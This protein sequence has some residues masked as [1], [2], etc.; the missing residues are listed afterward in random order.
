MQPESMDIKSI[1][2]EALEKTDAGERAA[3]LDLVCGKDTPQRSR[4]ESLLVSYEQAGGFLPSPDL[5]RAVTLDSA[6]LVEG[7]ATVVGRY[8]LLE[9]IGE[10]GMA[11][12]Y[13]AEQQEP[14]RRKVAL[15]IIKLGMDTRQIIAR[16]EAE[17][18]ALAVLDHPNIAKVFDAG[19]TGTGRPYFVME[20]VRGVSI[21]DYCDQNRL[22]T[23]ARLALFVQVCRAVQHAHHK[24]I[25]HRDLKPSNVMVTMHDDKPVPKVIDFGIAKAINDNQRLT[26]KTLFTRY[27]HM[28]GTPAYMS[29]EQAQMSGLDVDTRTDIYSL[30]VLLY[31]LLTGTTPFAPETLQEAGYAEIER[32]IRETNPPKPST[33]LRSLGQ[34]GV[35]AARGRH[36]GGEAL[37]RLV[38]GDLDCIAMKCLE[39][40]R[41]RRYTTAHEIAE[42]IERHLIHKPILARP[43]GI[44]YRTQKFAQRNRSR[45]AAASVFATL[46]ASFV[47]TLAMYRQHG[48][49]ESVRWAREQGLPEIIRLVDH[50]D[51]D[52]AFS[53]ARKAYQHIP[54]DPVL[55]E[56][57]SQICRDYSIVTAPAGAQ[58]WYR[59][60]S[61]MN[62]PWQY[63]GRSPLA[64][65]TLPQGPHRWKIEKEGF[66]THECVV[67]NSFEVRLQPQELT[68]DMVWI[69][70]QMVEL[71]A[72]LHGQRGTVEMPEH[73]IDRYEVT[74]KQFKAFVDAG[75][76]GN[77]EYW[78]GLDFVKEGRPLSWQEAMAE[79]RDQTG[80]S[81]PAGWEGGMYRP[82]Q[83]QHPVSG[84]SWFEAA[85]YAKFAG[86]SLPTV[87][88]WERAA[89]IEESFVIV[90]FSNFDLP[91]TAPVGSHPGVGHTGLYDMAGNVKEWCLNATDEAGALR[92]ILGGSWSEPTYMFT[93]RDAQSPWHR[94]AQNGF[95]CVRFPRGVDAEANGLC[96]P[97]SLPVGRDLSGLQPFSDEEFDTLRTLYDYDHTP[98]NPVVENHDDSSPFW[99][100][101]K[102]SFDAAYDNDRVVVH[103]FLPKSGKPPYQAVIYF[104]GADA[105]YATSFEGPPYRA[106][107]QC[108]VTSG[109][110]V[111]FPIYHGTYERPSARGRSWTMSDVVELPLTY[112]DWTV[113]MA[114]DLRRSIDY[115]ETRDDINTE[116]LGYYGYSSGSLL[117]PI[118]LAVED[119]IDT[120]VFVH[121]GV[122]PI[123]FPRSF[124]M[125]LYAERVSMPILMVN[126]AEDVLVP[127]KTSQIPMYDILQRTSRSTERKQYP[128][129]H[130]QFKLFYEQIRGDVVGWLDRYLGPVD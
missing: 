100:E 111:V 72:A 6:A 39:K 123:D 55:N 83:G 27:A 64:H 116:K 26:E 53:L 86:K 7:P 29:P 38:R 76:Y 35:N 95:R 89:C 9:K 47:V 126:G 118:M 121:G 68:G 60:Y 45:I 12:V 18:Q 94:L 80:Q 71:P 91:G 82:G 8:K 113:R 17:R 84:V 70:S 122:P 21:T 20:L 119:R 102:I 75:G 87:H 115:L 43:P 22:D 30:G 40:D 10:G 52:Q 101:E 104:P 77:A 109:R 74:N 69:G 28:I 32:I 88:D 120:G 117:G 73:L 14:I 50:Q 85:A 11:V 127:V 58:I 2:A 90:P 23:T 5:D 19:A 97:I 56:L 16:L 13:M 4:V 65:V 48:K 125:A 78:E 51:Y 41:S 108:I 99:R 57:W 81:G 59:E 124:D 44:I 24:G 93:Y 46:F 31:E 98:L 66:V 92:Y 112:R 34:N 79:F 96:R 15:K 107:W 128:G 54:E 67:E 49:A 61:A 36:T 129:G 37:H 110:A 105:I 130:G 114:K 3:Y 1:F 33:R 25:I 62:E 63:L 106:L 103:L 42:D